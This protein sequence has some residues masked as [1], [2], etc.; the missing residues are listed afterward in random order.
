MCIY[1]ILTF[2]YIYAHAIFFMWKRQFL[3]RRA[4]KNAELLFLPWFWVSA[5]ILFVNSVLL[6]SA[7]YPSFLAFVLFVVSP[8]F[9]CVLKRM[10]LCLQCWHHCQRISSGRSGTI[11]MLPNLK[12]VSQEPKLATVSLT[13]FLRKRGEIR[14][15]W[16]I[17]CCSLWAGVREA[18]RWDTKT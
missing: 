14:C 17:F 15:L 5:S 4:N 7:R 2:L 18:G 11:F 3:Y 1:N 12:S 13:L 8:G 16:I 6:S 9:L 10:F